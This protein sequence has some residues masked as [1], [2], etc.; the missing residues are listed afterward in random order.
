MRLRAF[1]AL[2]LGV[3]ALAMSAASGFAAEPATPEQE[4]KFHAFLSDFRAEALK[5]GIAADIYDRATSNIDVNPRVQELNEKQ[6]EFV[7]PVWEYLASAVSDARVKRGDDSIAA[8]RDL[9]LRLQ[10][11]YGVP[12]EVLAAIWG[13]ET[14]FGQNIGTFNLFEALATLAYDGPRV[15]YAKRQFIAALKIV[16]EGGFDPAAMT[17]S[18]AG[19]FGHTQFVPTTYLEHAIDGDGDGKRDLWNS[20]ADALASTANY[21]KES[22]W[23][24]DENWG[25]EVKLPDGFAYEL[26]DPDMRKSLDD[27]GAFGVAKMSG[28]PLSGS[29]SAFLFLPAGYRG[30]AFVVTGNFNA[31]LKYNFATSYALA[32]GL[33]S[34]RLKGDAPL[35]AN[36]PLEELPL[37]MGQNTALQEGLTALG[38]D[39]GGVDG[40]FGRR[41]RAALRDYQKARG[42][43]ADGFATAAILT[44]VLNERAALPR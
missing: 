37:D 22:G 20:P 40:A 36:W 42:L 13:M 19:A 15:A 7:R 25:E 30:P 2:C 10:S 34:D 4:M 8:N 27:W 29:D 9:L 3:S 41:S 39:T 5:A 43:P 26:A 28:E 23:R 35:M 17:S 18:W 6:P 21:L 38:F 24:M 11:T 44:K 1:R 14:N 33:L 31:I 32:I 12:E 16:Q